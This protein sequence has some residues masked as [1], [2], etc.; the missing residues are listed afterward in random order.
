MC[1]E[2]ILK[3]KYDQDFC[4]YIFTPLTHSQFLKSLM[5]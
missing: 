2:Q 5:D 4:F 3:V 1:H